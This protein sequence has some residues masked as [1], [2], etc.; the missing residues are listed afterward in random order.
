MTMNKAFT[1][2]K[3]YKTST[4]QYKDFAAQLGLTELELN[5]RFAVR[6]HAK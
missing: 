6:L 4:K 5:Q 2:Y 1:L 3:N